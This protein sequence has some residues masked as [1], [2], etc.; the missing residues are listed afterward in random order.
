MIFIVLLVAHNW[1]IKAPEALIIL[2]RALRLSILGSGK[3]N[4]PD[5]LFLLQSEQ[6]GVI[7]CRLLSVV[8]LV[9]GFRKIAVKL[10]LRL[11]VEGSNHF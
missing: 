6:L 5:A 10:L 4:L 1:I 8:E 3:Y 9:H 2:F 7:D 11:F